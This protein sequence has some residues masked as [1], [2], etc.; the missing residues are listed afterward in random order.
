MRLGGWVLA[1]VVSVALAGAAAAAPDAGTTA[2]VP[3]DAPTVTARLDKTE[4][5]VGDLFELTVTSVS[6]RTVSTNLPAQLDLGPF[7]V[8]SGDPEL[9]ETDLGDG[10]FRRSF[11]LK[12]AAYEPGELTLPP[13]PVTYIGSG[14]HVLSRSTAPVT[15]K[16]TSLL[17]NEPDP[18]LKDPA[19]PVT[20]WKEDLTLVYVAGAIV[21]AIL[22]ALLALAIRRRLRNRAAFRPAPPPRP[23]H[24]IALE[25]L[26]RLATQSLGKGADMK[27]FYFQLSDILRDYLG[28]R[29]GFLALEMTTEELMDELD[30][31]SP[32][33]LVMGEVAGWLGGCDLVKFA[34]VLPA[35][36]EAR[37]ALETAIRIVESTRPRPEPQ[38]GEGRPI[39]APG[40]AA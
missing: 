5:R 15:V 34:K 12:V 21:A 11:L 39:P 3:A 24:E 40:E 19:A 9:E 35:E 22:G 6:P 10:R 2:S 16:I 1:M 13:I 17:A 26:D 38:V 36:S 33:G 31:R 20:V 7:E 28:A 25:R 14:G 30:R 8:V 27:L 32:R 23:V 18:K 29:F 4:G 37:G